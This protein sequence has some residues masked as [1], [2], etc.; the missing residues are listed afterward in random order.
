MNEGWEKIWENIWKIYEKNIK[1]VAKWKTES[2]T[3]TYNV[4]IMYNTR[5]TDFLIFVQLFYDI[6]IGETISMSYLKPYQS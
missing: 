4:L 2:Q 3:W 5:I 6:R 1:E